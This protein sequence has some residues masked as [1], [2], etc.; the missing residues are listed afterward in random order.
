[1]PPPSCQLT[2][3][4][5]QHLAR[6]TESSPSAKPN[7]QTKRNRKH[8]WLK[9]VFEPQCRYCDVIRLALLSVGQKHFSNRFPRSVFPSCFCLGLQLLLISLSHPSVTSCYRFLP[10]YQSSILEMSYFALR[11]VSDHIIMGQICI[12]LGD[13]HIWSTA[14]ILQI[15]LA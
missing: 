7:K 5:V 14:G 3:E 2:N 6:Y 11:K 12:E 15:P 1:M 9:L 4:L 8:S 10:K 13:G